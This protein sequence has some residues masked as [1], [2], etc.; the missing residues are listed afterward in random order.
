MPIQNANELC[1]MAK[2]VT[3]KLSNTYE[4]HLHTRIQYWSA[5]WL[6][7]KYIYRYVL[8]LLCDVKI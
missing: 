2:S 1:T 5:D 4:A 6:K 8:K 3:K 7:V